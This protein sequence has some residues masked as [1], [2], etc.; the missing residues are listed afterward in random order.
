MTNSG[1]VILFT[2]D[3]RKETERAAMAFAI[4][5]AAQVTDT[6]VSI[7]FALDGVFAAVKGTLQGLRVPEFAPLDEMMAILQEE[8]AML[9][10][11]H[12]FLGPRGLRVEDLLDGMILTSATTLVEKGTAS[13][14]LTC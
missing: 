2:I 6:Q 1:L 13:S 7:F 9:H 10:V 12:P 8:G 3:P 14:I 4:A 11:C 5:T